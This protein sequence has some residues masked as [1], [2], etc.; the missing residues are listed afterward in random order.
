MKILSNLPAFA[1]LVYCLKYF[2]P[3]KKKIEAAKAAGDY[4]E[5]RKNILA[6]TSSWGP[7][8]MDMFGC[9]L[10]VEGLENLP[11]EGP[12]VIV[13][14][15]QGYADIAAYF[16]A[17]RKFQFAFVAKKELAKIPLYGKWMPR[18]RSVFIERDD[19]RA[20]LEAIK[21][22][23]D[24]IEKGFSLVIYP[25]GTRSKGPVP[26]P[27]MKGSLKL[28]TK[29]GVPIVPVSMHGTYKMYE[30][31]GVIRPATIRI[32]VHEP[33]ETKGL[34]RQEERELNDRVEKIVKDGLR[35]LAI[36]EGDI[37]E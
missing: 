21:A 35:E 17:F 7:M 32:I 12:V 8:I 2:N 19:P 20:S 10:V 26:G 6:A 23:I 4:E 36:Q 1:K 24:L 31:T 16:A 14:N 27:F 13:G 33:I 18:I 30:Q 28:A 3:Y 25:E 34:S 11:E 15:H 22:G 9:D 29:P 37:T 5:E